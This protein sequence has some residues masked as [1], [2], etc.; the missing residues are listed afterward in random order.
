MTEPA[1]KLRADARRNVE[2]IRLA[3]L[4]VFRAG[5]LNSP[6]DEVARG[7]GE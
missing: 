5:G 3:A 7:R 6:L 1:T 4:E 2:G